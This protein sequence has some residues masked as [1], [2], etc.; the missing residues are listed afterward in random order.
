MH[1]VQEP[2]V[3]TGRPQVADEVEH[4]LDVV[5]RSGVTHSQR[6]PVETKDRWGASLAACDLPDPAARTGV[7]VR[8]AANGTLDCATARLIN[9]HC[10]TAGR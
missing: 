4:I 8:G 9:D 3:R 6:L 10:G 2:G 5:P 1:L 7:E